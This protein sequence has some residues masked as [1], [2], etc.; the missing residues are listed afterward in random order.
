MDSG[1]MADTLGD[2]PQPEE[3]LEQAE[4]EDRSLQGSVY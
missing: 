2:E 1:K 3:D 4:T